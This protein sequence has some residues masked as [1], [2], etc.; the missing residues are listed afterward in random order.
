MS[1]YKLE[2]GYLKI[3]IQAVIANLSDDQ[4]D[5]VAKIISWDRIIAQL[6]RHLKGNTEWA[7][8]G[9]GESGGM[10]I[11]EHIE[12]IQGTETE[13]TKDLEEQVRHL[14]HREEYLTQYYDWYYRSYHA[15]YDHHRK[16][17]EFIG[18]PDKPKEPVEANTELAT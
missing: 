8:W 5:E 4:M 13:R 1:D 7:S 12:K 3:D 10:Y 16:L 18:T 2:D 15:D 17:E 9:S 14:K 6:D 11:R